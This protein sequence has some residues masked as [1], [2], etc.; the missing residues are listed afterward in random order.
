MNAEIL[1]DGTLLITAGS[2]LESYALLQ[3][4]GTSKRPTGKLQIHADRLHYV[5]TV[6]PFNLMC[7]QH[8]EAF[9][10]YMKTDEAVQ[11]TTQFADTLREQRVIQ[12]G[13]K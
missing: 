7:D 11:I 9:K 3:W 8:V 13:A 12:D 6:R 2:A 1:S 10:K 5:D 4:R